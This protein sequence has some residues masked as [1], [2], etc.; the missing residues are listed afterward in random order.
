MRYLSDHEAQK[1]IAENIKI[2]NFVCIM[3]SIVAISIIFIVFMKNDSLKYKFTF[4]IVMF[5]LL[6]DLLHALSILNM[7][8]TQS[9]ENTIFLTKNEWC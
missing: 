1:S 5:L 2:V 6:S 7:F 4:R 8:I 3:C 9:A